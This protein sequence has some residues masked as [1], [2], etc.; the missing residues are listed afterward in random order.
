MTRAIAWLATAS[1][2]V[3]F[4]MM[5][6][7]AVAQTVYKYE[8]VRQSGTISADQLAHEYQGVTA[9]QTIPLSLTMINRSGTTIKGK[10]ALPVG[11]KQVPVGVWGIGTQNPQDGT[12]SFLDLSSFVLNNNRFVYYDGADVPNGGEI[13][14]TWNIKM[15]ASLSNGTYKLYVRPVS[16][17]L[18]WTRQV[19]NG[20]TLPG[21]NSDIFWQFV[22]G[23]GVSTAPTGGLSIV[24]AGDTPAASSIADAGQANFTKFTMTPASGATV[25]VNQLFVMRDG[26]STDT[27]LENVKLL[28]ADGVQIG[29]TAGGF[30]ADHRAQ[31]FINPALSL[32][33]SQSF[34]LRAGV[35][36]ATDAGVTFRLGLATNDAV[37]SNATSVTGA[38][39]WGNFMTCVQV[40]IGTITVTED[41]SI[42]DSTPDVGDKDVILNTFKLTAGSVE[43]FVV[44]RITVLKA[45]TAETADA[46]N[47]ELWD[48]TNNKSL[49]EQ[50]A[51][52]SDGKASWA[53]NLALGKGDTIRLRVQADIVDGVGLTINCD[54]ADGSDYLVFARGT[55]YGFYV[56]PSASWTA[57]AG[58]GGTN[59]AG[60][61][62]KNQTINSG[63]VTVSKSALTPA[64]GN[65]AIADSQL[66]AVFAFDVK[67]EQVRISAVHVD[68]AVTDVSAGT[69]AADATDL[70]NV[71]LVD[72]AT[73]NILSG[74]VDGTADSTDPDEELDFTNTFTL[75][76]G[77][78]NVGVKGRLGA[79]SGTDGFEATDT[80]SFSIDAAGQV[81]VKGIITNNTI[82]PT[83]S[84]A[85]SNTLTVKAGSMTI[86]TL[87]QP[88]TG[89]IVVNTQDMVVGTYAFNAVASG[90]DLIVSA[91]TVTDDMDATTGESDDFVNWQLWADLTS[92][93]TSPRGDV[94]ETPIS[95]TENPTS[96]AADSTDTQAFTFT[97]P[98]TVLKGTSV[99]V[100][101]V[102]DV[103]SGA[104]A[105]GTHIFETASATFATVTGKD[106]GT[107]VAEGSAGLSIN[108]T[109]TI[110]ANGSLTSALAASTPVTGLMVASA[111]T[112]LGAF[113]LIASN[114]A[115]TVTKLS[116]DFTAGYDSLDT[117]KITYPTKTGTDTREISLSTAA[118]T[119]DNINMYV[120]KNGRATFTATGVGKKVG[121]SGTG[122]TFDDTITCIFDNSA[123]GE[124]AAV[125][126]GSGAALTGSDIS[127]Q[128]AASMFLYNSVPTIVS[129]NPSSVGTIVPGGTINL[130]KFKVT[131]DAAGAVALKSFH[132]SV[133]ITDASTTTASAADL[134]NF[135][136]LRD[137]TDITSSAQITEVSSN[138]S[139]FIATPLTLEATNYIENNVSAWVQVAFGQD[140]DG[141]DTEQV[142]SANQT[143]EY[144][145]RAQCGTGFTTTD[146]ISTNLLQDTT[147]ATALAYYLSDAD[148]GTGVE[149]V[150]ALQKADGTQFTTATGVHLIWSDRSTVIHVA[151]FDDDG[152]TET[153][154]ADWTNGY[155][156]K[157][158]PLSAYGYTL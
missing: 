111:I 12:P 143:V 124:F 24:L 44:D 57:D 46:T 96:D 52:T 22:V 47:I 65:I 103:A 15:A 156:V 132:Y 134:T 93:T 2:T 82:T 109:L 20:I 141:T 68:A 102:A 60:Q 34:Y 19:K 117:V 83:I 137:G 41:G 108:A 153:S 67:G 87:G 144:T 129:S 14:F 74:P 120:P 90:E 107:D 66:L 39:V 23:S 133:F 6:S 127:D 142:I 35:V 75:P 48:V 28:N 119:F 29:S 64:T 125:G 3:G 121:T 150:V 152:T 36:N 131:A 79:A 7:G 104:T 40:A 157:S 70:T 8:W 61:G 110:A 1:L 21:T 99:R 31:I 138:G 80:L 11:T 136:I 77:V 37:V 13:T 115:Y 98:I 88:A 145:L 38:P 84:A 135:T 126:E 16:E 128:T 116:L 26:L 100:V 85:S 112:T 42:S 139:S 62:D 148:T 55:T 149:Q 69:P 95:G 114:E 56:T 53:V 94:Y 151:S 92:G 33:G 158:Y 81:S 4:A 155:L 25:L 27:Q 146:A 89:S 113:D 54:I 71:R 86:E 91:F 17:F 58:T 105:N 59:N 118:A 140:P 50:A 73:G 43:G 101:L 78:S 51:W 122:G 10:S 30:N 76:V 49:G 32:T 5:P 154:S 106:T 72:M 123:A 97:T 63:S 130:Y 9:G 18:A 147:D 45:G